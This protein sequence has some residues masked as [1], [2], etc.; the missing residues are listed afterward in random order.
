MLTNASFQLLLKPRFCANNK[1][2]IIKYNYEEKFVGIQ[3]DTKLVFKNHA[4]SLCKKAQQ[5]LHVLT[6]IATYM[7]L[8]KRKC[9]VNAFVTFH[10]KY[11]PLT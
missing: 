8:N 2:I 1:K 5:K 11:Y 3:I 9:L 10:F 7:D 6:K 4:S